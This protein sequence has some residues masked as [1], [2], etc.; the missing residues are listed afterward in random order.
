MPLIKRVL[1]ISNM[2]GHKVTL[3]LVKWKMIPIAVTLD[4]LSSVISLS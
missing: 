4:F 1:N 2:D 3:S